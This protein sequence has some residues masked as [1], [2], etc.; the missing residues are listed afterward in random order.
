MR[1]YV[2]GRDVRRTRYAFGIIS[3]DVAVCVVGV[4]HEGS[5]RTCF[6]PE[7]VVGGPADG[8]VGDAVAAV[9]AVAAGNRETVCPYEK[10]AFLVPQEPRERR[11]RLL[12]IPSL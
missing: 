12:V 7:H 9:A 5:R 2:V 11:G 1:V 10:R 8:L 6:D 3:H 4:T